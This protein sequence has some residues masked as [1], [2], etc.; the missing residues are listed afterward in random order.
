MAFETSIP[1][2]WV[3]VERLGQVAQRH[4]TLSVTPCRPAARRAGT[5]VST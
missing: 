5:G 3:A 1:R 2:A 4:T